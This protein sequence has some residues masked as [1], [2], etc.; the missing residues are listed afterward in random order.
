MRLL[1][2]TYL[3]PVFAMAQPTIGQV[4]SNI[5][6]LRRPGQRHPVIEHAEDFNDQW[7]RITTHKAVKCWDDVCSEERFGLVHRVKGDTLLADFKEL[8]VFNDHIFFSHGD[9]A[10]LTDSNLK[11]THAWSR[12]Q[13]L[14]RHFIAARDSARYSIIDTLARQVIPPKYD[15]IRQVVDL[16]AP[17]DDKT[18]DFIVKANGKWGVV[19][20]KDGVKIKLLY[21]SLN[22]L[23]DFAGYAGKKGKYGFLRWD[24]EPVTQFTYDTMYTDWSSPNFI[25][26][27]D[28]KIGLMDD[29]GKELVKPSFSEVTRTSPYGCR[30]AK[31]NGKYAV[32]SSRGINLSGF[33]YDQF[34][35]YQA[36]HDEM[37]LRKNGKWGFF[38]CRSKK[39]ITPFIYDRV[40]AF[41][42]YE[43]DM[44]LKGV[45]KK[46]KLNDE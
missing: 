31:L 43:A 6:K 40:E 9:W 15:S 20:Y 12:A 11:V 2:I 17:H 19:N 38:G 8:E 28:N 44:M 29:D 41:Y 5:D 33:I 13:I 3:L 10:C 24:G 16:W 14:S 4:Q 30:C 35:P 32:I 22:S 27:R 18:P 46:I 25:V 23:H 37:L 39:E 21:E 34:T 45:K 1:L 7:L 42:G 26:T 36:V